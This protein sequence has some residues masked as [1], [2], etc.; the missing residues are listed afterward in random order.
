MN[1]IHIIQK[2]IENEYNYNLNKLNE[3]CLKIQKIQESIKNKINLINQKKNIN[4]AE[5]IKI[6]EKYQKVLYSFSTNYEKLEQN[7]ILKSK[8][9]AYK[10][11]E[12][13]SLRVNVAETYYMKEKEIICNQHIG[14]AYIKIERYEKNYTN[15]LNFSV[16][17]KK[18]EKISQKNNLNNN[19]NLNNKSKYAIY[20]VIN[21]KLVKLNKTNK[22]INKGSLNYECS[23]EENFAFN[24]KKDSTDISRNIKK[25]DF[26]VTIIITE[27]FL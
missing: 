27:L 21:N 10:V 16:S 14:N 23:L 20:M 25:D 8:P 3:M 9:K 11:Y 17:I 22:D 15:C 2:S 6:V 18:N 13:N 5:M 24:S 19:N 1:L 7:I 12:A 26:D 4:N